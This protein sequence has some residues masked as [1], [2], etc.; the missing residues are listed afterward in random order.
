MR[1]WI[2]SLALL[3]W[4]K[5]WCCCMRCRLQTGLWSGVAMSV[6]SASSSSS[7][8]TPSPRLETSICPGCSPKK[9]KKEKKKRLMTPIS[10]KWRQRAVRWTSQSFFLVLIFSQDVGKIREQKQNLK[11]ESHF[12]KS[13]LLWNVQ[14]IVRVR[15]LTKKTLKSDLHDMSLTCLIFQILILYELGKDIIFQRWL[16]HLKVSKRVNIRV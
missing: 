8:S 16:F 12:W 7:D 4:L 6:V 13:S 2:Q 11:K 5:V 9:N 1:M 15:A 14:D 10:N 3:S